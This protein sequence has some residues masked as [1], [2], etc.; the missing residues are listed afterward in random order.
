MHLLTNNLGIQFRLNGEGQDMAIQISDKFGL[1]LG[2]ATHACITELTVEERKQVGESQNI[3][4]DEL[5]KKFVIARFKYICSQTNPGNKTFKIQLYTFQGESWVVF[6]NSGLRGGGLKK[7]ASYASAAAKVTLGAGLVASAPTL[8]VMLLSAAMFG[9]GARCLHYAWQTPEEEMTV[10]GHAKQAVIG[11]AGGLAS[12]TA[13]IISLVA[14]RMFG[15]FKSEKSSIGRDLASGALVNL[16]RSVASTLIEYA[17]EKDPRLLKRLKPMPLAIDAVAGSLIG[18]IGDIFGEY[19]QVKG[20]QLAGSD[21][22]LL[23]GTAIRAASGIAS[24]LC[25]KTLENIIRKMNF[26][27][28]CSSAPDFSQIEENKLYVFADGSSIKFCS[29]INRKLVETVINNQDDFKFESDKGVTFD[30]VLSQLKQENPSL[31]WE[32]TTFIVNSA[33][34][35]GYIP[36]SLTDG[37]G[38]ASVIGA[39]TGAA[40]F[41]GRK[42]SESWK[43]HHSKEE[44]VDGQNEASNSHINNLKLKKSNLEA[45]AG[46]SDIDIENKATE[47][48]N[49]AKDSGDGGVYS[50]QHTLLDL[51]GIPIGLHASVLEEAYKSKNNRDI[52]VPKRIADILRD[53]RDSGAQLW[54][55]NRQLSQALDSLSEA[56]Q[57]RSSITAPPHILELVTDSENYARECG[58][59]GNML[60]QI[61]YI[62][63]Y[64]A[65]GTD[66]GPLFEK[67]Y[68]VFIEARSEWLLDSK[69][70]DAPTPYGFLTYVTDMIVNGKS[71]V[72]VEHRHNRWYNKLLKFCGGKV[73]VGFQTDGTNLQVGG[74]DNPNLV[75]LYD[76]KNQGNSSRTSLNDTSHSS[77]SVSGIN[78]GDTFTTEEYGIMEIAGNA[79]CYLDR[80]PGLKGLGSYAQR[81][82]TRVLTVVGVLDR[83]NDSNYQHEPFVQRVGC[84]AAGTAVEGAG[85]AFLFAGGII[86]AILFPERVLKIMEASERNGDDAQGLC[87]D[88]IDRFKKEKPNDS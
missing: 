24:G 36:P 71:T 40:M 58:F 26:L 82:A 50:I 88:T 51:Y 65:G 42:A 83:I 37:F 38:E 53:Q 59:E 29:V 27:Q 25:V 31:N 48:Y 17:I 66:Q 19:V 4:L 69:K 60:V 9:A 12:V 73:G 22:S 39:T 41:L 49:I 11:F 35:N 86:P 2:K 56:T 68:Y 84:A 77:R 18:L 52:H 21:T 61:Y 81:F 46:Y 28:I 87:H 78:S 54:S 15:F 67:I 1:N 16:A 55:I 76:S 5:I 8:P 13:A 57:P 30:Q 72:P 45:L 47:I 44:D 3:Q 62:A 7:T 6:G 33:Y 80:V 32:Q 23:I 10:S 34:V 79:L 85:S 63:K 64:L 70:R 14:C 74:M 43:L 20:E 75:T